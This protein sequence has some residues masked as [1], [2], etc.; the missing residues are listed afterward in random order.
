MAGNAAAE[1]CASLGSDKVKCKEEIVCLVQYVYG[2]LRT[3]SVVIP[4]LM[5]LETSWAMLKK[6]RALFINHTRTS[7]WVR[8]PELPLC[9]HTVRSAGGVTGGLSLR[10]SLVL[11]P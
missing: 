6:N 9:L 11:S 5:N 3:P 1:S 4:R 7:V 2:E 8:A 10:E